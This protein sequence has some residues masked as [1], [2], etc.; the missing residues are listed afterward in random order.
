MDD[1][2]YDRLKQYLKELQESKDIKKYIASLYI[3]WKPLVI[4]DT[5]YK[6]LA[7]AMKSL[8]SKYDIFNKL[9]QVFLRR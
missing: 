7:A 9:F 8:L 5:L 1:Y 3:E 6:Y 2:L 4:N